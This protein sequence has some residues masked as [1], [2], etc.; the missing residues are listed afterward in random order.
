MLIIGLAGKARSGKDT[1]ADYLVRKYGFIK[2]AFSD[3][4]YQEVQ[5]AFN[6]PD[7]S[8]L[9]DAETKEVETERLS[10]INCVDDEFN[11][12]VIPL[13]DKIPLDV[14][15]L[16]R[17]PYH[18]PLSPRQVLQW[19]GTEYRRAQNPRYW[20]EKNDEWLE[21][22]RKAVKYPEHAPACFVNTTV[23]FPNEQEWIHAKGGNVW[24]VWRDDIRAVNPHP[25]EN[26]LSKLPVERE[27]Y[28]LD[29]IA[30]LHYGVDLLFQT[31]AE[32]VRVE[33]MERPD[34]RVTWE[35]PG[36][37]PY[38]EYDTAHIELNADKEQA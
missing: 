16:W 20:L 11:A 3:A 26:Q 13:L 25:S 32:F 37:D 9:R 1:I 29:T 27:I 38:G 19:W 34:P 35:I 2:F 4:L 24:H 28:N 12:V 6:L 5:D 17:N 21:L 36:F 7:Q 8:L 18:K 10:L 31:G 23:R 22:Q 15:T 14:G 33:P 30:R